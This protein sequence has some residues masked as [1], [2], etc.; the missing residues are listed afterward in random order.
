MTEPGHV[1]LL[2]GS[3]SSGKTTLARALRIVLEPPHWYLSLDD[4]RRGY[5]E[6]AWDRWRGPWS[7]PTRPM[8]MQLLE[9]YLGSL[10]AMAMAGHRVVAESVILPVNLALYQHSLSDLDV[11]VVGVRCPIDVAEARERARAAKERN[12]GVPIELRVPEFD[13]VH[14]NGSYDV[15]VDTSVLSELECVLRIDAAVH[16]VAPRAFATWRRAGV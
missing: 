4:F 14:S 7:S 9:G 3:P 1:I 16:T 10:R 13:L 6:L 12:L 5:T 8:F 11:Y 15:E 2:N